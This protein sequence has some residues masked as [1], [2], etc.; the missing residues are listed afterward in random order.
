MVAGVKMP[1]TGVILE[2]SASVVLLDLV[3]MLSDDV[4]CNSKLLSQLQVTC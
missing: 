4:K 1:S 2:S 3:A